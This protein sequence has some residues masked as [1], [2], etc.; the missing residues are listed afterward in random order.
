MAVPILA[1]KLLLEEGGSCLK[2]IL[3]PIIISILILVVACCSSSYRG[4]SITMQ[5][6]IQY[7]R[8]SL[9]VDIIPKLETNYKEKILYAT[10]FE[11]FLT[12]NNNDVELRKDRVKKILECEFYET[13]RHTYIA[14]LNDDIYFN[15]IED[16]FGITIENSKRY[17]II[18]MANR[19]DL[20]NRAQ[21]LADFSSPLTRYNYAY[22][23]SYSPI[24]G[25][26]DSIFV[27]YCCHNKGYIDKGYYKKYNTTQEAYEDCR[28]TGLFKKGYRYGGD[29]F[30]YPGDI[31]FMNFNEVDTTAQQMGIVVSVNKDTIKIVNG[32]AGINGW[33]RNIVAYKYPKYDSVYI[34]GYYPLSAIMNE[35]FFIPT[36]ATTQQRR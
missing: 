2:K 31:I 28:K 18:E 3:V 16:K 11:F 12:Q 29:Y 24:S 8:K 1:K 26:W 17:E 5:E 7:F 23:T 10:Y 22:F 33:Q 20:T 13:D 27:S 36:D 21:E 30:P 15:N 25:P 34:I 32:N 9:V 14:E 4:A 35:S 19:I 6:V